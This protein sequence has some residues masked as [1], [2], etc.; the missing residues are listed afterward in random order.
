M[1]WQKKNIILILKTNFDI[2]QNNLNYVHSNNCSYNST[3]LNQPSTISINSQLLAVLNYW[4]CIF[5]YQ[6]EITNG[7]SIM[8]LMET[9]KERISCE[10]ALSVVKVGQKHVFIDKNI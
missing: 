3:L 6:H 8:V 2:C 1:C 4:H 7:I 9:M 10:T 5:N